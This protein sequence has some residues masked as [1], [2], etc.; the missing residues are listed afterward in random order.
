MSNEELGGD[1][2][3]T[4]YSGRLRVARDENGVA[5]YR[6]ET[7]AIQAPG[8]RDWEIVIN[9]WSG[10]MGLSR[11]PLGQ[12]F[13]KRFY[14]SK[15]FDST[16]PGIL[17]PSQNVQALAVTEDARGGIRAAFEEDDS[18]TPVLYLLYKSDLD[19]EA[20]AVKIDLSGS[21]SVDDEQSFGN[22]SDKPGQPIKAYSE[23]GPFQADAF[24]ADA[25][26]VSVAAGDYWYVPVN[27]GDRVIQLA[28]ISS[29]ADT[30]TVID[31]ILGGAIHFSRAGRRIW[32]AHTENLISAFAVGADNDFETDEN[33][34]AD[35]PVGQAGLDITGLTS[36]GRETFPAKQEGLYGADEEAELIEMIP[37]LPPDP[38]SKYTM[39][40]GTAVWHSK[41]FYPASRQGLA[42]HDLVG[43]LPVGPDA[44]PENTGDEPN[45]S[46]Q[47]RFGDHAGVYGGVT[48]W[49]Y[50]IYSTGAQAMYI[51]VGRERQRDDEASNEI[52]WHPLFFIADTG[53]AAGTEDE[54]IPWVSWRGVNPILWWTRRNGTSFSFADLGDDGSPYRPNA[55]RG[56]S[57]TS[58]MFQ[59]V[60]DLGAPGTLKY[61]REVEVIL[62]NATANAAWQMGYR[63]DGS[64]QVT[65]G[66]AVVASGTKYV[67]P[68]TND[69]FREIRP[70]LTC[71]ISAG[72]ADERVHC[73]AMI[74]RGGFLPDT[75]KVVH[76]IFD[77]SEDVMDSEGV[78]DERPS[79]EK[80]SSLESLVMGSVRAITDHTG[81]SWETVIEDVHAVD[82]QSLGAD[83]G[84]S[85]VSVTFTEVEYA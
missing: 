72:L 10:G 49:L 61:V 62:E 9:D 78:I 45:L 5:Q 38:D 57:Q 53:N 43:W 27:N 65:V 18:G 40:W 35:T 85:F 47:I 59:S 11:V 68:R 79:V 23:G 3:I 24:Q 55:D 80:I 7:R 71:V 41:L 26:E 81:E 12:E 21:P 52:T 82:P 31:Q 66:A 8:K 75:G 83:P 84:R 48:G 60:Y 2:L 34:G 25:F 54:V 29:G 28:A 17:R 56:A 13:T 33:W 67:T 50:A 74:L 77:M 37:E 6:P 46:D 58:E 36:L 69:T 20:R 73:R 16:V 32:R 15:N 64:A 70:E 44:M 1:V 42:R 51:L 76:Y 19:E 39:G 14:L 30:W 4:G 22:S 63:I